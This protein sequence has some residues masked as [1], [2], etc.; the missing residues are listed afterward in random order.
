MEV[1]HP[2]ASCNPLKKVT[3]HD[4]CF[5][6]CL[7][8]LIRSK[9]ME[10]FLKR[11]QGRIN[12]II[13]GFD[14]IL[15]RGSLRSIS[16]LKA[17]DRFLAVHH[18][19][20]KDF[21]NFAQG[22]SERL[23]ANAETMAHK[24][25]RPV[26]YLESAKISKQE[27]AQEFVKR[28][29]ITKGLVCVLSCV[30]P[31]RS[32]S[33]CRDREKK[34]LRLV[35]KQ[36]KCLHLYFYYLDPNFGLMHVRL[37]TWLPFTIQICLNGWEWLARQLDCAGIGYELRDNCFVRIDDLCRAQ[38]ILD[39]LV[40]RK[41]APFLHAFARQVN[42]WIRK[43]SPL[44]LRS[45]Y[46][47][48]E[49]QEYSTDVIFRDSESLAALYPA[50]LRHAIEHFA[51]EDILR[52][53]GR[54]TNAR[55]NGEVKTNLRRRAEGIRI[56]HWVEENSI[57]MY[58]KQACVLRIET[59]INNARRF[60]V[61]RMVTRQG[62]RLM[63]WT[64]MRKGIVDIRRRVEVSRAANER[65]LEALAVVGD[66]SPSHRLLDPVSKQ[67]I[68]N[69]RTFRPLRPIA[70][71]DSEI[72]RSI[73]RGEF[74]L[75][76]FRNGDLREQ[77]F[78]GAETHSHEGRRNSARVTRLVRLLRAHGLVRKVPKTRY[79]RI[80]QKGHVVMT[81]ALNFRDSNIA[82]LAA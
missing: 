81:T 30:E 57:K 41:W 58:D 6:M 22:L 52:F 56:K 19:L 13:A 73:L 78:P 3:L 67:V 63:A 25:G 76:G 54:R 31:C 72:F 66:P 17:M 42:P 71:E 79:Y 65:Y 45:Y 47:G 20:Y 32:F 43:G 8:N 15:F 60:K 75:Q 77:L 59:T 24:H 48:V 2:V 44:S 64:R 16:Y 7:T 33:I 23:K 46:W 40:E 21:C 39:R 12:G 50:L 28:Y 55:F 82:L 4:Y 10:R 9:T 51:A 61:R 37:Q 69:G 34:K 5:M 27:I 74:A 80:S 18:V 49:E 53:L 38:Q 62:K 26:R 70:P 1:S 14:R 29:G 36:T 68:V 35:S 11:H